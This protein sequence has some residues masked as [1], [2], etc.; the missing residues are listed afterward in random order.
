VRSGNNDTTIVILKRQADI[1]GKV[2]YYE[3]TIY[4]FKNSDMSYENRSTETL[5]KF[6]AQ[7]GTLNNYSKKVYSDIG[8]DEYYFDSTGINFRKRYFYYELKDN[9]GND[10]LV[11]EGNCEPFSICDTGS[12]DRYERLYDTF[13]NNIETL[14]RCRDYSTH[15]WSSNSR[16]VNFFEKIPTQANQKAEKSE[17]P[18]I[19]IQKLANGILFSTPGI[20][21]INCF[22]IS[23]RL[24]YT[25]KQNIPVSSFEFQFSN[26]KTG[27]NLY[28]VELLHCK[29]KT[30][31]KVFNRNRN[32]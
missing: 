19:K 15:E 2:T 28:I 17:T 30:A 9:H 20:T 22:T 21:G 26:L 18:H 1:P 31:V 12:I 4:T 32:D 5:Q 16:I 25:V 6:D 29:G 10:T 8:L 24:A 7:K 27:S 23:G 13:G 11:L 14:H 3:R